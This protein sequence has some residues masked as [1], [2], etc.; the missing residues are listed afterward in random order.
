MNYSISR[1]LLFIGCFT[2]LAA[3]VSAENA[4][5]SKTGIVTGVSYSIA[6]DTVTVTVALGTLKEMPKPDQKTPPKELKAADVITLSGETTTFTLAADKTVQIGFP[7]KPAADEGE[8]QPPPQN[9]SPDVNRPSLTMKDISITEIV[10]LSFDESGKTVTGIVID[11]PPKRGMMN[12]NPCRKAG[13]VQAGDG[14]FRG[15][16]SD[17][18]QR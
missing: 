15:G 6:D 8:L 18:G 3:F 9:D 5:K 4:D 11:T 10:T 13:S 7:P 16:P 12:N 2:L 14:G 1:K 17:G